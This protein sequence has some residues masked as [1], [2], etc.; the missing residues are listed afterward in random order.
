EAAHAKNIMHRDLKPAN[1]KLSGNG[2]VKVLDFGLAKTVERTKAPSP[3]AETLTIQQQ[4][5]QKMT[6]IGTPAYMS[7]EQTRGEELDVRTD[8][9]S[10]GCVLYEQLTAKPAYAGKTVVETLAAVVEREPDW[11]AV[12]QNTPPPL[13]ALVTRGWRK[14]RDNRLRNVADARLELE[15]LL[16]PEPRTAAQASVAPTR[17]TAISALAGAVAG[18]AATEVFAINRYRGAAPRN[19]TR[20]SME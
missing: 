10:F 15:D 16:T 7:P 12:L 3:D 4:L 6:V 20:F 13:L 1:I 11:G 17:R 2:Q 18:V 14:D 8:I 19:V 9:W 5:T